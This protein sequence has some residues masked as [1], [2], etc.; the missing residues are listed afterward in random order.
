MLKLMV[1]GNLTRDPETRVLQ[2][3]RTVTN[4]TVARTA[5]ERAATIPQRIMCG[6]RRGTRWGKTARSI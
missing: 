1:I 6:S 3:G 4:F 5:G 2:D